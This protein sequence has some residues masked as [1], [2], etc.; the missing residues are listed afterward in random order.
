MTFKFDHQISKRVEDPDLVVLSLGAGV[1]STVLALMA[2][3]KLI[4]PMPDAMVFAD[5]G[6]EP[7]GV[8]EHLNWL[9]AEIKRLTNDRMPLYKVAHGNIRDDLLK[10]E[11]S[12]GQKFASV[13][14]FLGQGGMIRRQCTSEYK[15]KPLERKIRELAG[16]EKGQKAPKGLKIEQWIGISVDEIQR[17][18]NHHTKYITNR[19][20]LLEIGFRRY[21][22]LDWF[23][24][25]Y[26]DRSLVKSACIGC[27]FRD[28]KG[29]S[30][31]KKNDP[32]SF[33]DAVYVDEVIR[34]GGSMKKVKRDMFTHKSCKPLNEVDFNDGEDQMDFGFLQECEG[35]CGI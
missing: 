20:P 14:Y 33:K 25:E 10:S 7:K 18:K 3:K 9:E 32:E 15:I 29:W 12:T 13:P 22:C 24:K 8:Y 6:W 5:T 19:W 4:E 2:A 30:E 17:I 1:Q 35:M 28:D 26:P 27:P 34:T 21:H 31:M 16:L 11:N 23:N